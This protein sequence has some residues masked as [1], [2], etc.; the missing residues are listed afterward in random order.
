MDDLT[1]DRFRAWSEEQ[2]YRTIMIR[3]AEDK[4]LFQ[5]PFGEG[6][7]VGRMLAHLVKTNSSIGGPHDQNE[8]V[9]SLHI[10][11]K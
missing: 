11:K 5:K 4:Q 3:K 2:N 9:G 1:P 7:T 8:G 10:H 6:E